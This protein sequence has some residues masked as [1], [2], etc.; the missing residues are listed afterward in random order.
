MVD[1]DDFLLPNALSKMKNWCKEIENNSDYIGVGAAG[2]FQ[3]VL[4]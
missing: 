3:M 4:I 2:D 1:S